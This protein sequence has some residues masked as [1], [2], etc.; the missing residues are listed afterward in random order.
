M[1]D[2]KGV[3]RD[4]PG[5]LYLTTHENRIARIDITG[6]VTKPD[7]YQESGNKEYCIGARFDG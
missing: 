3:D 4:K 2:V 1:F 6:L 7:I 5:L